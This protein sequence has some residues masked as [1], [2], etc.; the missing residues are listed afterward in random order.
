MSYVQD[1]KPCDGSSLRSREAQTYPLP[2]GAAGTAPVFT[3]VETQRKKSMV[4]KEAGNSVVDVP[5]V[6]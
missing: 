4:S 2:F 6:V 3:G 5:G 1:G